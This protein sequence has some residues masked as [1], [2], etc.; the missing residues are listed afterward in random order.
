MNNIKQQFST[1]TIWEET[2]GFSRAIRIGNQIL[3]AGTTATDKAEI[4]GKNDPA[5][6]MQFILER[7]EQAIIALGGK[8]TDVVRT[9]I[10]VNDINDWEQV[11]KIHGQ[12]FNTIK[13]V[14]T[15]VQ[16]KLV[17]ECL[18]EVEAEAWVCQQT[19]INP[20]E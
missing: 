20:P 17:G 12:I 8:L 1:G 7:I 3:V 6:Q 4:V 9:R 5:R 11:A 14:S 10:F 18:V 15:L 13:P 2:A 19:L 16:A